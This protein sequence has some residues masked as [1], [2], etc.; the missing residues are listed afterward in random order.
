MIG[1]TCYTKAEVARL[2]GVSHK[3]VRNRTAD[4]TIHQNELLQF[5]TTVIIRAE[6]VERLLSTRPP[7][8]HGSRRHKPPKLPDAELRLQQSRKSLERR[9]RLNG[10]AG[11]ET[12]N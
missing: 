12:V 8:S 10:K 4:G 6:A 2:F 11:K 5:G 9:L 7:P 3:T 1:K